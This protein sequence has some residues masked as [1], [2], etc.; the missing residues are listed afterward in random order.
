MPDLI[1]SNL[2]LPPSYYFHT[3]AVKKEFHQKRSSLLP[4][5]C[6]FFPLLL[7]GN[8][9]TG[10][11]FVAEKGK[12]DRLISTGGGGKRLMMG[13]AQYNMSAAKW[14]VR[15]KVTSSCLKV[16]FDSVSLPSSHQ[17]ESQLEA[18]LSNSHQLRWFVDQL[19]S[20][21]P[22]P[23]PSLDVSSKFSSSSSSTTQVC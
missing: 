13:K 21:P 17:L 9:Q 18:F 16:P 8:F 2:P 23:P 19:L 20:H 5:S 4:H 12:N 22:P 7:T 15:S 1:R 14:A 6:S 11:E 10:L 3:Q